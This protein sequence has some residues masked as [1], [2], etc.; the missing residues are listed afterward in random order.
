[1]CV[2]KLSTQD[3]CKGKYVIVSNSGIEYLICLKYDEIRHC[4][5]IKKKSLFQRKN[6]LN[7]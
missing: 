2:A 4:F 7:K 5:L 6:V 3:G 1:M